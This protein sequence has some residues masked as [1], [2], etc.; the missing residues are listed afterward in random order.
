MKP[1]CDSEVNTPSQSGSSY[2]TYKVTKGVDGD[3]NEY[4]DI[5]VKVKS[6]IDS[7]KLNFTVKPKLCGCKEP[8]FVNGEKVWGHEG[9]VLCLHC[10]EDERG[11]ICGLTKE[12]VRGYVAERQYRELTK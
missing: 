10:S 12:P 8:C 6:V 11:G 7:V 4:I 1:E 5:S 9:G 3:G 2:S